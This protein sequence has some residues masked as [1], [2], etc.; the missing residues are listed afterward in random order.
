[1]VQDDQ[2]HCG[3]ATGDKKLVKADSQPTTEEQLR[4]AL[5]QTL[6]ADTALALRDVNTKCTLPLSP[7]LSHLLRPQGMCIWVQITCSRGVSII[8]WGLSII[9]RGLRSK[10]RF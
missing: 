2:G 7:V 4:R 3:I 10:L 9:S 1:M 5:G 6:G 8:S